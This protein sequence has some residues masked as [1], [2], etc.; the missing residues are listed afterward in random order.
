MVPTGRAGQSLIPGSPVMRGT[1]PVVPGKTGHP[2]HYRPTP[3]RSDPTG[4]RFRPGVLPAPAKT[5]ARV[6]FAQ[7]RD[8]CWL[9]DALRR[10]DPA[11]QRHPAQPGR[12][13]GFAAQDARFCEGLPQ[14]RQGDVA[15]SYR[16]EAQQLGCL[17]EGQQM[18]GVHLQIAG[19]TI[20]V[21]TVAWQLA[22]SLQQACQVADIHLRQGTG[23]AGFACAVPNSTLSASVWPARIP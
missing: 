8:S 7:R 2:C 4:W 6:R 12:E 13:D 20:D 11:D 23:T 19:Q 3:Q 10:Q 14:R 9:C 5:P 17:N 16:G 15:G 1:S 18:T 22:Q 21:S